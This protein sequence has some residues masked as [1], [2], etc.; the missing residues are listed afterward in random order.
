MANTP[1]RGTAHKS[2]AKPTLRP[3]FRGSTSTIDTPKYTILDVIT[4]SEAT[5]FDPAYA[6][7]FAAEK[8]RFRNQ[9]EDF[10]STIATLTAKL[11]K[12]N[13]AC[14]YYKAKYQEFKNYAKR[15]EAQH[16]R[17]NGTTVTLTSSGSLKPVFDSSLDEYGS[18]LTPFEDILDELFSD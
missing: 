11:D 15:L 14:R 9:L 16:V 8:S 3:L 13:E 12:A 10:R 18:L 7:E 17:G 5:N 4:N 6:S 1:L 2:I